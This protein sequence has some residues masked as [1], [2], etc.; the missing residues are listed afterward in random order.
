MSVNQYCEKLY[1]SYSQQFRIDNVLF[2]N[3][4]Q[5]QHLLIFENNAFGRV[6][7]LDGVIQTTEKDEFIYHEMMA[8][9]PLIAH[10]DPK[11]VLIIG[12][13]DGGMLREVV[14]HADRL[15]QVTQVEIDSAVIDMCKQYLP[16][17]SNGAFEHPKAHIV[18]ADGM[19]YV[20]N[21]QQ[22]FDI[23]IS[24]STDPIGPG[25]IL[26]SEN[27]Y[28]HCHRLLNENGILVTQNG[29][30]FMQLEELVTTYRRLHGIFQDRSFYSA[31]VPTYVGGIMAFAWACD[32]PELRQLEPRT[33]E[34]RARQAPLQT[35]YYTPAIHRAAFAMPR[36]V[37][38]AL[39]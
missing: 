12:G 37:L 17:H 6:M 13:G 5:H 27:F 14:K 20:R 36:Y 29:V 10:P 19:A 18:I 31:A 24:D 1:D 26:F 3:Q 9:V 30:A 8:H 15:E 11:Q 2:E 35:R 34:N 39:A 25:E 28:R 33:L 32:N 21:C 7:A 4:T 38:Q 16:S 22:R 23:I